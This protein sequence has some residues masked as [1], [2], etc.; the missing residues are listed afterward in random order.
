MAMGP[1]VIGLLAVW[2]VGRLVSQRLINRPKRS[3]AAGAHHI[4]SGQIGIFMMS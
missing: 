4:E 2:S 1:V 3:G